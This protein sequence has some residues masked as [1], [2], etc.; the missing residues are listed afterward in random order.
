MSHPFPLLPPLPPCPTLLLRRSSSTLNPPPQLCD[1]KNDELAI[2]EKSQHIF[3]NTYTRRASNF[4][5]ARKKNQEKLCTVPFGVSSLLGFN[6]RGGEMRGLFIRPTVNVVESFLVLDYD[7]VAQRNKVYL[8]VSSQRIAGCLVA[9]PIKEAFKSSRVRL[10]PESSSYVIQLLEEALR[11]PSDG[12]RKGQALNN[13]GTILVDCGKLDQA[14]TCYMNALEIKHTRAHQ[15]LARR[16]EYSDREMAKN[17]LNMTT[18]LDPLRTYP[19]RYR[20]AVL[21]DDLKEIEA[22]EE[23]TKAIAFKPDLQMLH[24]PPQLVQVP[25]LKK[26]IW[27]IIVLGVRVAL[28]S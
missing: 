1:S 5:L 8:F 27:R 9:E 14:A 4:E 13:L 12:L 16:S 21:M 24:L 10:D 26:R 17:D 18:K 3:V 22:V 15:G 7:P 23:L 28:Y 25:L 20:A 19:Y 6:S 2:W 11:C